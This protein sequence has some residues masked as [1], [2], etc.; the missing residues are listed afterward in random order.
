MKTRELDMSITEL[1][2]IEAPWVIVVV[3]IIT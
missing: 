2:P 3:F 1:E